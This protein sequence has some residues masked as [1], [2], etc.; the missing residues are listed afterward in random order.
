VPLSKQFWNIP[1][2]A[3]A[4]E[5]F[6]AYVD[7]VQAR[8]AD[9]LSLNE[10]LLRLR[11]WV[12]GEVETDAA[13]AASNEKAASV[14][15]AGAPAIVAQLQR[16]VARARAD[17]IDTLYLA[18]RAYGFWSLAPGDTLASILEDLS[19]GQPLAMTSTALDAAGE[20]ILS[21]YGKAI[22]AGMKSRPIRFPPPDAQVH[23]GILVHFT[24][25]THPVAIR[26][27][28]EKGHAAVVLRPARRSTTAAENPFAGHLNVRL[29][30]ARCWVHGVKWKPGSGSD[31]RVD[32]EHQGKESIVTSDDVLK[33]V[34]HDPVYV[35]TKYDSRRPGDPA[36]LVEVSDRRTPTPSLSSRPSVHSRAVA[37]HDRSAS[38]HGG[39]PQRSH[40]DHV[41]VPWNRGLAAQVMLPGST[42][43]S[44]LAAAVVGGVSATAS[45]STAVADGFA[46]PFHHSRPLTDA[47]KAASSSSSRMYALAFSIAVARLPARGSTS[48]PKEP[49]D[50]PRWTEVKVHPAS[51]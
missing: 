12:A 37:D 26:S 40:R 9:I 31:V 27:L 49:F 45:G 15:L 5:R 7:A 48:A 36:G 18:S 6:E 10:S 38:E 30:R 11:G 25:E 14:S 22:D 19:V 50:V 23:R 39:R 16:M 24:Q 3:N 35:M 47:S 1:G 29:E 13:I 21:Q 51:K 46:T 17:C 42:P 43:A 28:R 33:V 44:T 4:K 8:N 2:A 20:Q 34:R 32:V 41:R